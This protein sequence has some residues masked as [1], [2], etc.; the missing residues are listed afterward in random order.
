MRL[1][2]EAGPAEWAFAIVIVIACMLLMCV[3]LGK[4]KKSPKNDGPPATKRSATTQPT[5]KGA[6]DDGWADN[7]RDGKVF[8]NIIASA[9]PKALDLRKIATMASQQRL[10][11]AFDAAEKHLGVP[12]LLEPS[13]FE[14]TPGKQL[15]K[16]SV[17]T[18]LA[19][20]KQAHDQAAPNES[21][22]SV[23]KKASV[24]A[25]SAPD[26]ALTL[27][28][29][30]SSKMM[31]NAGSPAAPALVKEGS[32]N[33]E[34][35]ESAVTE[36]V[37]AT[38]VDGMS[39]PPAAA[40]AP[41]S[42]ARASPKPTTTT[43]K[44]VINKE[45]L[46]VILGLTLVRDPA[47]KLPVVSAIS[48]AGKAAQADHQLEGVLKEGDKVAAITGYV[49]IVYLDTSASSEARKMIFGKQPNSAKLTAG[50]MKKAIGVLKICVLRDGKT[51]FVYV[52][53]EHTSDHVGV[54]M[55][56]KKGEKNPRVIKVSKGGKA[57]RELK[58]GDVILSVQAATAKETI[59]TGAIAK[60]QDAAAVCSA[61]LKSSTGP[62][63][64]EVKRISDAGARRASLMALP[65]TTQDKHSSDGKK[66]M[67][68]IVAA[69]VH[70]NAVTETD[71]ETM[72][73]GPSH[74]ESENA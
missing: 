51:I 37:T 7:L 74:L 24:G 44:I 43:E 64:L 48:A 36:A 10:N 17:M 55:E 38:F 3:P 67:S 16:K 4:K 58:V 22:V 5:S 14:R 32:S 59:S 12:K 62:I 46:D 70:S 6:G 42:A 2:E 33:I 9:N 52:I 50:I 23:A 28:R 53:K 35:Q 63:T 41:P 20:L 73:M 69:D 31:G 18:Y 54:E 68:V 57:E 45:S 34:P 56:S 72:G 1:F 61:F 65:S 26:P 66:K 60:A 27:A 8:C 71:L 25:A 49:K 29:Q 13:D 40:A 39:E 11:V 47:D 30:Q 21:D 19:K 15:D